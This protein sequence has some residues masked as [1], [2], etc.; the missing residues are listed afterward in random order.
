MAIVIKD[1]TTDGKITRELAV[2]F[3]REWITVR[4]LIRSYVY[5]CVQ[6]YNRIINNPFSGAEESAKTISAV[7]SGSPAGENMVD[8]KE[9]FQRALEGF[10][11]R[12][13]LVLVD[14]YQAQELDEEVELK[15]ETQV[16]FLRL[17]PLTGG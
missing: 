2:D 17:V 10:V 12:N 15:K 9:P 16:C 5:E 13:Y 7:G 3:L 4:E 1:V 11:D 8:W 14:D 6:D